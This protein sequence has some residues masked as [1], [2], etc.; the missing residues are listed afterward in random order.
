MVNIAKGSFGYNI[1]VIVC[2]S[3]DYWIEHDN[4]LSRCNHLILFYDGSYFIKMIFQ[5][6]L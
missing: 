3:S 2:P 5:V 1:A 4:Q 6:F